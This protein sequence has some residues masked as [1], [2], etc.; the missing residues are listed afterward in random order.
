M[1][2]VVLSLLILILLSKTIPF[3]LGFLSVVITWLV[4]YGCDSKNKEGLFNTKNI[5]C[6]SF[7]VQ[8]VIVGT[9][10]SNNLLIKIDPPFKGDQES[11]SRKSFLA[12]SFCNLCCQINAYIQPLFTHNKNFKIQA[13]IQQQQFYY[14]I[15]IK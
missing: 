7:C 3:G 15:P 8:N 6:G 10:L 5:R 9:F 2:M 14:S 11:A 4:K 1:H 12:D 13:K